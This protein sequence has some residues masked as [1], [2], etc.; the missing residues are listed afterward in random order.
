[1][2][3]ERRCLVKHLMTPVDQIVLTKMGDTIID[4]RHQLQK[5][6]QRAAVVVSD[7]DGRA[8]GI[9]T[10]TD[11]QFSE[12]TDYVSDHY[13]YP[14]YTIEPDKPISIARSIINEKSNHQLVVIDSSERPVG[15]L[16]DQD[17]ILGCPDEIPQEKT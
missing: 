6:H 8:I 16:W 12:D 7:T 5:K 10:V 1:M 9:I 13:K 4:L 11:L 15:I 3:P 17:A 14:P 2:S